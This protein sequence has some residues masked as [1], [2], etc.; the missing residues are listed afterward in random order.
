M[1][2]TGGLVKGRK[3]D[4]RMSSSGTPG[5]EKIR[6]T[7]AKVREALFG[8]IKDVIEGSSFVDLYAG[9][10]TVGMEALSRGAGR[11]VFVEPNELLVRSIKRNAD[12]FGFHE[13]A[14]VVK[15]R[16][17][18]FLKKAFAGKESFDIFFLDPPYFSEEITRVLP[19]IGEKGLLNKDGVVV[20][21]HFSK[22]KLPETAGKLRMVRSYR[23]GDTMLTFYVR[24]EGAFSEKDS[25]LSRDI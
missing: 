17:H 10:G 18:S 22:R 11:V 1:R 2:I 24:T 20:V 8:I 4:L 19:F 3:I 13:K 23:Y 14:I 12:K 9:T 21:E 7:S 16:A 15:G 5:V 25:S 6:P